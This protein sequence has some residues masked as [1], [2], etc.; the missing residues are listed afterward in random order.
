[1]IILRNYTIKIG[2]S[3][4]FWIILNTNSASIIV[5][6]D[7][8]TS[9]TL[10]SIHTKSGALELREH[11]PRRI[12]SKGK[13][14]ITPGAEVYYQRHLVNRPLN[15][16]SFRVAVGAGYDCADLKSGYFHFGGRWVFPLTANVGLDIGLGPTLFFR[17]S[18]KKR[19]N[20]LVSDEEGFWIESDAFLPGYQHKWL[21]GGNMELQY[22][23]TP[24]LHAFWGVV[25]A[26]VVVLV[27]SLGVRY[28]F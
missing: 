18:W 10:L 23:L 2:I 12:D 22:K 4:C 8:G 20:N 19:F 1:L 28:S 11:Y 9:L 25:P 16:N 15:A 5:A 14:V 24:N 7:I 27:N 6:D 21:I 26:F 3:I 17:E 13:Y